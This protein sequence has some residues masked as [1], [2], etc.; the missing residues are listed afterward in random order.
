MFSN[1][2]EIL[3]SHSHLLVR[4]PVKQANLCLG[5]LVLVFE[6][7]MTS[8][9]IETDLLFSVLSPF[10]STKYLYLWSMFY[11]LCI[12]IY[13]LKCSYF[14]KYVNDAEC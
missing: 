9:F 1:L 14:L 4:E 5:S 6:M 13:F 8:K 7:A 12:Y 2:H 11:L 3:C 10:L